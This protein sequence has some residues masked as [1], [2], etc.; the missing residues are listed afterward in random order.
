MNNFELFSTGEVEETGHNSDKISGEKS[1]QDNRNSLDRS[2]ISNSDE[3]LV[4]NSDI[5]SNARKVTEEIVDSEVSK[6][7]SNLYNIREDNSV[8]KEDNNPVS[9]T[10]DNEAIVLSEGLK[11]ASLN[12]L[13]L[14]DIL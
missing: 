7:F 1:C 2:E 4:Q 14:H 13:I 3:K 11:N 6:N 9:T 10:T 8:V 5:K 12:A